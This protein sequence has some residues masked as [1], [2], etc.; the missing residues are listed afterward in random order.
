MQEPTTADIER[1]LQSDDCPL[2]E[3][4]RTTERAVPVRAFIRFARDQGYATGRIEA[5]GDETV[6]A[7]GGERQEVLDFGQAA[8]NSVRRIT[9][10]LTEDKLA[11]WLLPSG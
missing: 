11:V 1:L 6:R 5:L 9:G 8:L 3:V 2:L 10:Q 7:L 4:G